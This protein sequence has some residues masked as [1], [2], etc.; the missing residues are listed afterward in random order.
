MVFRE[1]HI[2]QCLVVCVFFKRKIVFRR[3]EKEGKITMTMT[4]SFCV[5]VVLHNCRKE[6]GRKME[7]G[8]EMPELF[9]V[10]LFESVG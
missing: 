4:Y 3:G 10:L 6:L 9:V 5:C 1:I 2:F 7:S 8:D